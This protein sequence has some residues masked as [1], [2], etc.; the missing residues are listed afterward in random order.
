MKKVLVAF[1]LSLALCQIGFAG[2]TATNPGTVIAKPGDSTQVHLYGDSA[3]V[4]SVT[5]P[6]ALASYAVAYDSGDVGDSAIFGGRLVLKPTA[7]DNLEGS[8]LFRMSMSNNHGVTV[9]HDT[10]SFWVTVKDSSRHFA[11]IITD[12]NND[13]AYARLVCS[14]TSI[15]SRGNLVA[16]SSRVDTCGSIPI[17]KFSLY[18][19]AYNESKGSVGTTSDTVHVVIKAQTSMDN[20]TWATAD[21]AY[22]AINDTATY[23]KTWTL[24]KVDY[25]R[26]L[27]CGRSKN[28]SCYVKM[29]H[30]FL[31]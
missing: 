9:S 21:S 26:T 10:C 18:Y 7:A 19:T 29:T 3:M 5:I 4:I 25:F 2:V 23:V 8:Y 20:I 11:Y 24:P 17:G 22:P 27:I 16:D 13:P 14:N 12:Q 31:K 1:I 28:D 6:S 30:T 15:N